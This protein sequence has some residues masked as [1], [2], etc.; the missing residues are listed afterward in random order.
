M[1]EYPIYNEFDNSQIVGW[2]QLD[3]KFIDKFP[4]F[5]LSPAFTRSGQKEPWNLCNFGLIRTENFINS[6]KDS[7]KNNLFN[8]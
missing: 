2:I 1:K 3:D 7:K 8:N 6:Y 5:S 4:N